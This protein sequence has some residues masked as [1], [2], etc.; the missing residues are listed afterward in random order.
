[1]SDERLVDQTVATDLEVKRALL[2]VGA[3]LQI[4]YHRKLSYNDVLR[5]VLGLE[6]DPRG[7]VKKEGDP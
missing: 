1:M 6:K 2:A 4:H 3:S 7:K 5:I